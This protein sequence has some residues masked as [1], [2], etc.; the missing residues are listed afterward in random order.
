[1]R[2]RAFASCGG[3]IGFEAFVVTRAMFSCE[4]GCGEGAKR[5]AKGIRRLRLG[6]WRRGVSGDEGG[7]LKGDYGEAS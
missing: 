5:G 3:G 7:T 4:K 2:T 6:Q 1:M